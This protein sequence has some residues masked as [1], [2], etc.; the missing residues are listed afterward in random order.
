MTIDQLFNNIIPMG[1]IYGAFALVNIMNIVLGTCNN[2]LINNEPFEFRRILVSLLKLVLTAFVT[3]SVVVG[4]NLLQFGATLYDIAISDTV[5][6]VIN[7]GMFLALYATAFGQTCTD[8][9][10][11]IKSMFEIKLPDIEY[12]G[13]LSDD[14]Q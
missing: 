14:G 3:A 9:Y 11:K 4:F 7:I 8:I 1:C 13:G 2:C 6:Q 10:N 12:P 5:I